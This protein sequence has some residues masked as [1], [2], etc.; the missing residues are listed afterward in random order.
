M[1]DNIRHLNISQSSTYLIFRVLLICDKALVV[2][3]FQSP[4]ERDWITSVDY[5]DEIWIGILVIGEVQLCEIRDD[6]DD[7]DRL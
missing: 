5:E 3:D 7:I 4:H 1:R 2:K 6:D